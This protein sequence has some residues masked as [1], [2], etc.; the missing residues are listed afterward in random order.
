[1]PWI[2]AACGSMARPAAPQRDVCQSAKAGAATMAATKSALAGDTSE[3]VGI[4][5]DAWHDEASAADPFHD[6]HDVQHEDA[7][8]HEYGEQA[9]HAPQAERR[10]AD[11]ARQ[12]HDREPQNQLRDHEHD[13]VLRVPL[14]FAV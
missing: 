6:R 2:A 14:H 5:A 10:D 11:D 12:K 8:P 9:Q 3:A 7:N 4:L 1:M 13:A